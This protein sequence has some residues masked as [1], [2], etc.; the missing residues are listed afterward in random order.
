MC[1]S[2][3]PTQSEYAELVRQTIKEA[4]LISNLVEAR[5]Q[6]ALFASGACAAAGDELH[7]VGHIWGPDRV[8]GASPFGHG[9]DE[10]IGISLVLRIA[11]QL[12]SASA[13][14]FAD[15]QSY[16]AAA[17]V[18]QIV[19]VEYLAWA[20]ETRDRDAERWLRSDKKDRQ[21]FFS[22]RKLRE[23]SKGKFRGQDYGY[24]CEQGGHPTP[25]AYILLGD[26]PDIDGLLMSDLLGH[27]GR[28]W[29]HL[30]RWAE[31][32]PYG[33][34]IVTRTPEM[35]NRF[36]AWKALDPL[37]KLPPPP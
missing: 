28:I 8:C 35:R 29:E 2:Q 7:A 15:R 36:M 24:H 9:N 31:S 20:F 4:S 16:A 32:H 21:D 13:K 33:R 22:P 37:V 26:D 12:L 27:I 10:V 3:P 25:T 18:R 17:L 34:P 23:A 5:F 14:L 11:S 30:H 19:E 1:A 6:L